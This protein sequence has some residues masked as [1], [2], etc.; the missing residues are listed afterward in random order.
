MLVMRNLNPF[1]KYKDGHACQATPIYNSYYNNDMF[2]MSF[3]DR[4]WFNLELRG[5]GMIGAA[6]YSPEIIAVDVT[7]MQICFKWYDT[8]LN[9]LFHKNGYLPDDWRQQI[10]DIIT[11]LESVGIY[12][13]NLYPHTFYLKDSKIHI[14]DLHA[15]LSLD[16]KILEDDI[17]NIINDKERFLFKDGILD[18]KY[19]YKYTLDN[20]VGDWP[21][22]RLNG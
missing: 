15:C 9:H 16:D 21:G 22:G 13:L 4:Y 3:K 10:K 1:L 12:K 7:S 14:M 2:V 19:A 6:E 5:I 20:N 11:N 17:K 8:N 18:V